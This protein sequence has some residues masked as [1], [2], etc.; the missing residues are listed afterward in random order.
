MAVALAL[1][2][3]RKQARPEKSGE[4]YHEVA[5]VPR[6]GVSSRGPNLNLKGW[7]AAAP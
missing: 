6:L 1:E 4:L 3:G 2:L 7:K 5:N